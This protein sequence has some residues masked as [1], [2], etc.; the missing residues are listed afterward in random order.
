MGR[1]IG[2]EGE[3]RI[4]HGGWSTIPAKQANIRKGT[5]RRLLRLS[6]VTVFGGRSAE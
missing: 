4:A 6:S 2:T 3:G 1:A 5:G